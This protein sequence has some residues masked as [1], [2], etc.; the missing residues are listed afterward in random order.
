[1]KEEKEPSNMSSQILY[2]NLP[3]FELAQ[4]SLGDY[5]VI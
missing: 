5:A 1:M 3:P 2:L 4:L